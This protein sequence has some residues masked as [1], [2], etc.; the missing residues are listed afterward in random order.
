MFW[1][2]WNPPL[3]MAQWQ[4]SIFTGYQHPRNHGGCKTIQTKHLVSKVV[5][6]QWRS[7]PESFTPNPKYDWWAQVSWSL[8][9]LELLN[10]YILCVYVEKVPSIPRDPQSPNLRNGTGTSNTFAFR[11]W[12]CTPIIIWQGDWIPRVY[13][14]NVNEIYTPLDSIILSANVNHPSVSS[15]SLAL[16]WAASSTK[17]RSWSVRFKIWGLSLSKMA[18]NCF[19]SASVTKTV[20]KTPAYFLLMLVSLKCVKDEWIQT[21][22]GQLK[23]PQEG[24]HGAWGCLSIYLNVQGIVDKFALFFCRISVWNI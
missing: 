10:N 5:G 15:E 11:R 23:F 24:Q 17:S 8:S 18:P 19:L 20:R 1:W 12:L 6:K 2:P 9:L 13:N 4:S 22:H 14:K 21:K 16:L 3:I 7:F